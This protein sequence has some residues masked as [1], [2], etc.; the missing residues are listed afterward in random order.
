M[1]AGRKEEVGF[2]GRRNIWGVRDVAECWA[3]TGAAPVSVRWVDTDKGR[4]VEGA[5]VPL[6]RCRLVSRDCKGNDR[7]RDDLFVETPPF[8]VQADH[9]QPCGDEEIGRY[10][11]RKIDVRECAESSLE[12]NMRGGCLHRL[13]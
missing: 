7:G 3:R 8:G 10:M 5:G 12:W 13:T 4:W 1:R 2:M 11:G 6:V 9:L